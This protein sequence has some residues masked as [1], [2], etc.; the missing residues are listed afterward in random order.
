M[1]HRERQS[2]QYTSIS[3]SRDFSRVKLNLEE[4]ER[5][6]GRTVTI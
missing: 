4:A 1:A 5:E 3:N 6:V 2:R